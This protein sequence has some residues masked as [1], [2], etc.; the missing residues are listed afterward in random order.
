MID[1]VGLA[2]RKAALLAGVDDMRIGIDAVGWHCGLGEQLEPFAPSTA[3]V[4][5]RMGG[6]HDG[7]SPDAVEMNPE[8]ALYLLARTAE[9]LLEPLGKTARQLTGGRQRGRSR[10][11][12]PD[13]LG[14]GRSGL[15]GGID[16]PG[17]PAVLETQVALDPDG[18]AVEAVESTVVLVVQLASFG[19]LRPIVRGEFA[20]LVTESA[21]LQAQL[22]DLPAEAMHPVGHSLRPCPDLG[23]VAL[24]LV[25]AAVLPVQGPQSR[26]RPGDEASRFR[27]RRSGW[28]RRSR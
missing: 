17:E 10:A 18:D 7:L 25:I 13:R 27:R 1:G 4:E 8:P 19:E 3:D 6:R 23:N 2:D 16:Q 9:P 12:C 26:Q 28:C 14:G 22:V 24:Q 20:M 21:Q 5:Q 11:T 15:A